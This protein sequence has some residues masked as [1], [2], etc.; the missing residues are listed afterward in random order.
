[1]QKLL[2]HSCCGPCSSACIERLLAETDYEI[3]IFYYNPNIYPQ[4]E[5]IKR[6][7]EQIRLIKELNN[8]RVDFLDCD[9][10][11][12]EFEKISLGLE[13]EKE[14]GARCARCFALRLNKTAQTAKD[15]GFNAFA[16]TLTVSPHKNAKLITEIGLSWAEKFDIKYLPYDFKKKECFKRS[17]ALSKEYGLYRQNYCGCKF[18]LPQN[19]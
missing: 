13:G 8:H 10:N 3:T 14:G 5:Y 1:M 16:T 17:I 19:N 11:P 9:Y 2:L 4:E 7:S 6:K 15:K 12:C 18:S